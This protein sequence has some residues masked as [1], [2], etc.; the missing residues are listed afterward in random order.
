MRSDGEESCHGRKGVHGTPT[1]FEKHK[2]VINTFPP[3]M[4]NIK[5]SGDADDNDCGESCSIKFGN[6]APGFCQFSFTVLDPKRQYCVHLRRYLH[7]GH[8]TKRHSQLDPDAETY[9]MM[10]LTWSVYQTN[11]F[12]HCSSERRDILLQLVLL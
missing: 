1:I 5:T 6:S 2:I 11:I 8:L 7:H 3:A 12:R 9:T 10:K 4:A